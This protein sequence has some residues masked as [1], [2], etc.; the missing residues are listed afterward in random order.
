[1]QEEEEEEEEEEGIKGAWK[2][3]AARY[4]DQ[5]DE[6]RCNQ[7]SSQPSAL[8][9]MPEM[10]SGDQVLPCWAGLVPRC[11]TLTSMPASRKYP[12]SA[13]S[14]I[15]RDPQNTHPLS[16]NQRSSGST[17]S[18]PCFIAAEGPDSAPGRV[19]HDVFGRL[20]EPLRALLLP[21][22]R[23]AGGC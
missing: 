1:M 2:K 3:E 9:A 7:I 4:A 5:A 18:K 13:S 6:A 17:V 14:P 8:D 23:I 19:R 21:S 22:C 16:K 11:H 15:L 10:Q 12:L 20:L